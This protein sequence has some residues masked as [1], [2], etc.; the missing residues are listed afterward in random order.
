MV[1]F[2][3]KGH[4][5]V[6]KNSTWT[7]LEQVFY[8]SRKVSRKRTWSGGT[9]LFTATENGEEV[10]YEVEIRWKPLLSVS[11]TIRRNGIIIFTDR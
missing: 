10:F 8:D 9:H 7:G 2:E 6:V 1:T 4:R 5:I 11:T 3:Y